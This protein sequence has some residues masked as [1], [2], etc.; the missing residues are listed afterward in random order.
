M[1]EITYFDPDELIGRLVCSVNTQGKLYFSMYAKRFI[2]LDKYVCVSI[3]RKEDYNILFLRFHENVEKATFKIHK[4]GE[5]RYVDMKP[6]FDNLSSVYLNL[7]DKPKYRLT[8]AR[9]EKDNVFQ[10]TFIPLK[11]VEPKSIK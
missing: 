4:S 7:K 10:L 9:G 1:T 6:L 11:K 5:K 3:G 8:T 2:D